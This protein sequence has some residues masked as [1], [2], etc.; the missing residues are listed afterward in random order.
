MVASGPGQSFLVAVFVDEM[1]VG[2]G[3]SR[4]AF[5]LLYAAGTV[6]SA[7]AMLGL[8]RVADRFGL[9]A[10]W[11][12]AA[13]GL[14]GACFLAGSAQGL[15]TV[16]LALALLRTFGQGSLPLVASLLVARSFR[17]RRGQAMASAS[18]GI[19]V[20][21][22]ALPPL[23]VALILELG[24]RDAYRTLG[25]ALLVLVLP[26]AALV[27]VRRDAGE[28]VDRDGGRGAAVRPRYPRALRRRHAVPRVHVPTRRMRQLLFVL[29]APPLLMTA[30]VFH[31]V[32][33]LG[34]R[35]MSLQAAALALSLFGAASAAGTVAAGVV[36]DRT[37][38]RRLLTAMS[39]LTLAG[40]AALIAPGALAAYGGFVLIGLAGGVFAVVMGI[41][42]PRTYGV[43]GLGRLQG[44]AWSVQIAGAALGPL[45][46]ALS[47]AVTDGYGLALVAL[48]G[49]ALTALVVA[50]RWRDPRAVRLAG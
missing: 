45:P 27:R 42:W 43:A 32:S 47:R 9:R 3:L 28:E 33:L 15:V 46:L 44:T 7:L 35:G 2:T 4:T 10:L 30:V 25:L 19:T 22:I 48:A 36:S 26:L 14:A 37:R 24:W 21:S 13:A 20:A 1:L 23:A 39:S 5:S 29:A 50:A 49:Y 16:F 6:V 17:G 18:I 41:V 8:G 34:D 31:A 12:V 40:Y 38:T 11:L